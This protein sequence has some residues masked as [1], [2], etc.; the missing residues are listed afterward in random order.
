MASENKKGFTNV[1]AINL[2]GNTGKTTLASML[3][4]FNPEK[5]V[6][7]IESIN[8]GID[9]A[10]AYRGEQYG[11]VIEDVMMSDQGV[12]VD[13]GSS[14]V[15]RFIAAMQQYR[16]THAEFD[17]FFVPAVRE[18][19]QLKDTVATIIALRG[20]G[21]PAKK[22][23]VVFNR[24]QPYEKVEDIFSPLIDM[25]EQEKAF[26]LRI[27]A[28]IEENDVYQKMKELG[29]D[30]STV[31][32]DDT[33]WVAQR[34]AAQTVD[35]KYHAVTMMSLK[36]LAESAEINLKECYKNLGF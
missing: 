8:D 17:Y 9:D 26:D 10:E 21:V 2:S 27:G 36:G 16:G 20:I 15:E 35:E 19:K 30:L 12:I 22:I 6:I 23:K 25:Y 7:S 11:T 14:N 1:C 29:T 28:R 34:R 24:L 18:V 5:K 3:R 4:H 31:L 32:N 13:V 33:D